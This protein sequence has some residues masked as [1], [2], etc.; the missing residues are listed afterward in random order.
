MR[1]IGKTRTRAHQVVVAD[2]QP[3]MGDIGG[4]VVIV[5]GEAVS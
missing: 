1:V 2:Y 3:A 4:V 5:E